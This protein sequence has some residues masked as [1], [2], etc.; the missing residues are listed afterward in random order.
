MKNETEAEYEGAIETLVIALATQAG[1]ANNARL[2]EGVLQHL[3]DQD[4]MTIRLFL[5]CIGHLVHFGTGA[6]IEG[7]E[8]W[9]R[10][11]FEQLIA[12]LRRAQD[13]GT[14]ELLPGDLVEIVAGR[15]QDHLKPGTIMRVCCVGD[16][17]TV[18][19]GYESL[20]DEYLIYTV[21]SANI[22]RRID[23]AV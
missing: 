13:R 7:L 15:P 19:V 18:D 2:S 8:E 12:A 22:R 17:G 21:E 20:V 14:G 23:G 3:A 1:E 5:G 11:I 4:R 9:L 16:D 6:G 10:A